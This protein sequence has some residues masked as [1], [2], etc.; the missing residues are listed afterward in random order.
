MT[1]CNFKKDIPKKN[2][3]QGYF[4]RYEETLHTKNHN[5]QYQKNSLISL[6]NFVSIYHRAII[7]AVIGSSHLLVFLKMQ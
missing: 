7:G 6:I 4:S 2:F 1:V 3:E 5:Y